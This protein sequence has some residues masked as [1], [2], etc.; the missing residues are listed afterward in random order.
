MRSPLRAARWAL[1]LAA[2]L[3]AAPGCTFLQKAYVYTG[4]RFK[5]AT[6]MV[7]FGVTLTGDCSYSVYAC[8][9]GL[10]TVGGGL[11][12][13]YF[14]GVG[15]GRVGAFRH[16]NKTIGLGLYSYEEFG[17]GQFDRQDAKTLDHKHKGPIGLLF[18]RDKD[19]EECV[20]P[21]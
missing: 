12:D 16:Y 2:A 8:G 21:T 14:V 20:G 4:D 19:K 18:F 17:W 1:A 9:G 13:G 7:D 3:V 10:V 6:D 5:D 11:V 15:G